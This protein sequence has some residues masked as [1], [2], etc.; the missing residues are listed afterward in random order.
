MKIS[1]EIQYH[2]RL[3]GIWVWLV[4]KGAGRTNLTLSYAILNF[5]TL[6]LKAIPKFLK[7]WTFH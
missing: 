4:Q 2:R 6:S 5:A 1:E 7:F 3:M